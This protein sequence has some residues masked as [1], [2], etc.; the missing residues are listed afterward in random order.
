MLDSGNYGILRTDGK[1]DTS[2][3]TITASFLAK[4]ASITS[5]LTNNAVELIALTTGIKPFSIR[6]ALL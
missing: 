4:L 6:I 3:V 5:F 2:S 1:L